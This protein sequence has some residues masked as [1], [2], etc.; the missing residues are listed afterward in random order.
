MACDYLQKNN[1][2]ILETNFRCFLGEIDIIAREGGM[3]VFVEVKSQYAHV[4]IA[5]ERKV[6]DRKR[7]KLLAL[8]GF[9][10]RKR[11]TH[12]TPCRIDVITIRIAPDNTPAEITHYKRI[13]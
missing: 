2:A 5:P 9:Y 10:R 6:N 11:L 13:V 1:Y 7:K 12:N 8:A 3:I 4:S